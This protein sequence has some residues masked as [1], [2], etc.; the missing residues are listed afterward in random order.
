MPDSASNPP[1]APADRPAPPVPDH[2]LIRRIGEGAYGEVWLARSVVGTYRAVKVVHRDSFKDSRPYEREYRGIQ[3][4]EPLSRSNDGFVDIL[5]IGRNDEA[6]HFYYV[7]ELADGVSGQSA[8]V[9]QQSSV[10][11]DRSL[12]ASPL[13]ADYLPK[14]LRSEIQQRGRLPFD[15]CLPF[16]MSLTLAL[17][18]LHRHGLIH[19]DIKPSNII[20]VGGIPKLADIGLVAEV[21]EARSFV[22]TEGFVAPEG[23]NTPQADLYSLGKV[24][25]EMSMGKDRL[26]FP[27]P[28]TAL[29][30][31]PDSPDLEEL[32]AIIVKACAPH[33]HDR[34]QRAEEMHVD[35]ALLQS[36]RSVK[37]K[38]LLERRLALASKAAVFVGLLAALATGGYLYQRH[39]TREAKRLQEV[40]EDLTA[41]MQIQNAENLFERGD[42]SL[43]LAHL[44]HV[45]RR[46]PDNRVAA[47]R[48]LAALAQ[49]NFPRLASKPLIQDAKFSLPAHRSAARLS[50]DGRRIL[51]VCEDFSVRVWNAQT[52]EEAISP[53][54]HEEE[55]YS[56][57]FSPDG[58]KLVTASDDRTACVV[59]VETGGLVFPPLPHDRAV[60]HAT[61]SPDG[62]WIATA[63]LDGTARVFD[64]ET[65]G[66]VCGPLAHVG[67]MN[68]V[69]FSPDS[70]RLATAM[71]GGRIR[72][73]EV[74]T[75]QEKHR[76][77][78]DGPVRILR[79]SPDGKWIAAG[80]YGKHTSGVWRVQVW[81]TESGEPVTGPLLHQNRIYSLEFSPDSRRLVTATYNNAARVWRVETG[82]EEFGLRHASMVYSAS[83]S[84]DGRLIL[85]A[86]V[87]HTARLWDAMTGAAISE[88]MRHEGRVIHA[89]FSRDGS[90][91]LTAGWE[92]RTVKLWEI[93]TGRPAAKNLAHERWV[94]TAEFDATGQAA[95]TSTG[96]A[97]VTAPNDNGW[98]YG[99]QEFVIVW[100]LSRANPKFVPAL[101]PGAEAVTAQFTSAGPKALISERKDETTYSKVAWIWNLEEGMGEGRE[102]QHKQGITCAHF[103]ANGLKIA[104][105]SLDGV[106]MIW[107]AQHGVAWGPPLTH[108]GRLQCVRFSADGTRLIAVTGQGAAIV[109]DVSTGQRVTE[110]LPHGAPV[111][112]AQFS[113]NGDKVVT[114]SLDY[115]A[116]IWSTNGHLIATLQHRA[117][118]EHAEFS[119]DGSRVAT[120]SGN[121]VRLWSVATGRQ[122]TEPLPHS[123]L[124]MSA[125]FSADGLRLITA[126]K[127]RTAQVWDAQTG[128]KLA[129]PFQH[130]NWVISARFSADGSRAITASL[131]RTAKIW[132]VPLAARPIPVWLPELAEAVGG[133]RLNVDRIP[134]PVT[135]EQHTRLRSRLST[136]P[137]TEPLASSAGRAWLHPAGAD[138]G[139]APQAWSRFH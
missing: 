29:G 21:E 42:S 93:P 52:G 4:F 103:S 28:F 15:E 107:D 98:D 131:D 82:M 101:P 72:I 17:G 83:F 126:S 62:R 32:N 92:D 39:Q 45:L 35:L 7:M 119:P 65:G 40:A 34:Y 129:D 84:P 73:W 11:S 25:Y 102:L 108:G 111:W 31:A 1:S 48:I 79:F 130:D 115:T 94:T 128:L 9:S 27:E 53:H 18:H 132:E 96:G 123:E 58:T 77:R 41:R 64:A 43:A 85:T 122:L 13:M 116:K 133:Q 97:V 76:F 120:A 139:T 109:W 22:G 33:P 57:E 56:A 117:S 50:P 70:Q 47:E 91:V 87:D 136:L 99:G 137:A 63:S 86:S 134:E 66:L 118:V 105:G 2:E 44:A 49:R 80:I 55:V 60:L 59:D 127:D 51:T 30:R 110:P 124:V 88:A 68:A 12:A 81:N 121:E 19:R 113:P 90:H 54:R 112:F 26:D 125:R 16:A 38:R 67:P 20:F 5:Q 61:F 37:A 100:D 69:A 3:K 89:E 14:T 74:K 36:G 24:L 104:T 75:S 114:A 23:P 71:E 106:V 138:G 6:G 135:W 8:V 46:R 10:L 78:P 95:I